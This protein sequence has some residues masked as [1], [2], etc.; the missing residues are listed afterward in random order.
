MGLTEL[1]EFEILFRFDFGAADDVEAVVDGETLRKRPDIHR[2]HIDEPAKSAL[3]RYVPCSPLIEPVKGS[4]GFCLL[5][6]FPA[7]YD[8]NKG[9]NPRKNAPLSPI[10]S[11]RMCQNRHLTVSTVMKVCIL[12][13]DITVA[14]E[15]VV[16]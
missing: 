4:L 15:L 3:Q 12:R 11:N 5:R 1:E 9:C 13:D 16:L 8:L 6:F 10:V 2:T 14:K 7:N